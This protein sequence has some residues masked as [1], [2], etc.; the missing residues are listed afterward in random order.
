MD[1]AV[2][3]RSSVVVHVTF[4]TARAVHLLLIL[5]VRAFVCVCL[6]VSAPMP[7]QCA[8]ISM[9]LCYARNKL[10]HGRESS[11]A[12]ERQLSAPP[13]TTWYHI[14][15][16]CAHITYN[17]HFFLSSQF[18]VSSCF[19]FWFVWL[20]L[21]F[22]PAPLLLYRNI[23]ILSGCSIHTTHLLVSYHTHSY[24]LYMLISICHLCVHQMVF[25]YVQENY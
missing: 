9:C 2:F 8:R 25:F 4:C 3:V 12:K 20:L 17:K 7:A 24:G 16:M 22:P 14:S 11:T 6:C 18:L 19:F 23:L 10:Q 13:L 21:P 5:G 15:I 1:F